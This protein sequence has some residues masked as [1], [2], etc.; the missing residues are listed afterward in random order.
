M[1]IACVLEH[2]QIRKDS[3]TRTQRVLSTRSGPLNRNLSA[4]QRFTAVWK[5]RRIQGGFGA[6]KG[7]RKTPLGTQQVRD[8]FYPHLAILFVS[9]ELGQPVLAH[10]YPSNL[11]LSLSLLFILWASLQVLISP[12]MQ[13][14]ISLSDHP[15]TATVIKRRWP[16]NEIG[17][18]YLFLS[19]RLIVSS[20]GV[21]VISALRIHLLKLFQFFFFFFSLTLLTSL[22]ATLDPNYDLIIVRYLCLIREQ[23]KRNWNAS[24]TYSRG[25]VSNSL[26]ASLNFQRGRKYVQYM[27]R[28]WNI[29]RHR[30]RLLSISTGVPFGQALL[31]PRFD[32]PV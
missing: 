21:D 10:R 29:R 3:H 16:C 11:S 2:S 28:Y 9:L 6:T 7:K 22:Q 17:D 12:K 20:S 5:G 14:N 8:A 1:I 27:Y 24:D 31:Q 25:S 18:C 30:L 15:V 19:S 13:S 4:I 26:A 32:I 23:F